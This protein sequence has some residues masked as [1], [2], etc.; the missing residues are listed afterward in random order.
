MLAVLILLRKIIQ[1][2]YSLTSAGENRNRDDVYLPEEKF[3]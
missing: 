1:S 2:A 3:Y